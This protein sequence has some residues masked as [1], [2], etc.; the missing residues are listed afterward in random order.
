MK[1]NFLID[2]A[3]NLSTGETDFLKIKNIDIFM[4]G[5][6]NSQ[7]YIVHL[8]S[9]D[10]L[11]AYYSLKINI[12]FLNSLLDFDFYSLTLISFLRFFP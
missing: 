8:I 11:L 10:Q 12:K 7:L 1:K 9:G 6:G 2:L 5:M 3:K 4:L